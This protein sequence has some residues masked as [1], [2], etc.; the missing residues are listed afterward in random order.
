MTDALLVEAGVE[1]NHNEYT[2]YTFNLVEL[3]AGTKDMT[4]NRAPRY[5]EWKGN[6]ATTWNGGSVLDGKA[7]WF[8]RADLVY[9]GEYFVDESNLA[10]A[11]SQTLLDGRIGLSF[12]QLRV[13]LFGKN[14]TNE[15]SWASAARWSDFTIPGVFLFSANQGIAVSPQQARRFGI[16]VSYEF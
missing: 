15:T 3:L 4:G 16:R 2:D 13:E 12:D 1:W 5:P 9:I 6:L 7:T 11:P 10:K 8:A 14:L